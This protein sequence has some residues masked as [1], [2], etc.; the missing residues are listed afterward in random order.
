MNIF[1]KAIVSNSDMIKKYK[2]CRE[3]AEVLG[4]IFIMKNNQ[5]DAVLFSKEE[6][7]R[8]SEL[9]EYLENLE[10]MSLENIMKSLPKEGTRKKYSIN[11]E[12]KDLELEPDVKV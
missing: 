8:I 3:K 1:T 12:E 2:S 9:V 7:E 11:E 4:K 5:P 10:D 6:Y